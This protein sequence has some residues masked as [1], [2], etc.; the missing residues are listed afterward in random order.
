MV[1]ASLQLKSE[2]Y[3]KNMI[4]NMKKNNKL[5]IGDLIKFDDG[6]VGLI[7]YRMN[8]EFK[9]REGFACL[10]L[11]H[12]NGDNWRDLAIGYIKEI[13]KGNYTIIAKSDNWEINIK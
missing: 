10:L 11:K 4:K 9:T 1:K 6:V 7:T 2:N 12:A 5:E 8:C 3:S 13:D